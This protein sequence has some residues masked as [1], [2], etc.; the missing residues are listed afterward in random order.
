MKSNFTG[1]LFGTD[2]VRGIAN[3][4]LSPDLALDIGRAFGAWLAEQTDSPHVLMAR[5]TRI[6]GPMLATAVAAGLCSAGI[7]VRDCGILTT[8]GLCL[9]VREQAEAGGVVISA[10]HNPPEFNGIKLISSHGEKLSEQAESAVERFLFA[11]EDTGP[12]VTGTDIG[13]ITDYRDAGEQ[14]LEVLRSNLGETVSLGGIKIV[15]DCAFGAAFHLGPEALR[16]AGAEVSTLNAAPD[17]SRINDGCGAV[18]PQPLAKRVVAED[19]DIGVAFDGD[20]DRAVF[21]DHTGTVRDGDFIKFIIASDLRSRGLLDPPLVVG[22]VMSNLGLEMALESAGIELIRVPVG[23]RYVLQQMKA[24][25]AMLGGE[26]SGH[27]IFAEVGVGDGV[28]TAL[29][30]GEVIAR[31]GRTLAELCTPLTKAP[32]ILLNVPVCDKHAYQQNNQLKQAVEAWRARLADSGRL[33]IRPSGTEPVVRVMVEACDE[34]LAKEAAQSLAELIACPLLRQG[35][36]ELPDDERSV[37][38]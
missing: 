9:L 24:H 6:S 26:Q 15:V 21:V 1:S 16:R 11:E 29:R 4:D 8:P 17:G 23:D 18:N 25:N 22:T 32:Q 35:L 30:V 38:G 2:G 3:A 33:L 34:D 12:G 5:D 27:I 13:T 19:A 37:E 7:D 31:T 28:Y 20:A 10:S 36:V 14:Y